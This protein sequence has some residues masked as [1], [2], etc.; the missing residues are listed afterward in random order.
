MVVRAGLGRGG[1]L[2]SRALYL[3]MTM[4]TQALMIAAGIASGW[5]VAPFG[6]EATLVNLLIGGLVVMR[7]TFTTFVLP[8]ATVVPMVQRAPAVGDRRS[9]AVRWSP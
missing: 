4:L 7:L 1:D 9:P 3:A 6:I 8:R 2:R 5:L